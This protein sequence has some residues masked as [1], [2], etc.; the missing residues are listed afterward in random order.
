MAQGLPA[1]VCRFDRHYDIFCK[2]FGV[3]GV[4]S[5]W[6]NLLSWYLIWRAGHTGVKGRDHLDSRGLE[7]VDWR[8]GPW[9][10]SLM[11]PQPACLG[12]FHSR[13]KTLRPVAQKP[14]KQVQ[15]R[16][17]HASVLGSMC[18]SHWKGDGH[19]CVQSTTGNLLPDLACS[20]KLKV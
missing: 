19:A 2:V 12:L 3:P 6:S 13:A 17:S 14:S 20:Q 9:G 10:S 4:N 7:T 8:R 1:D 16:N 5:Q 11:F 18:A 15:R